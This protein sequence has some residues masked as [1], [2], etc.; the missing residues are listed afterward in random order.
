M[1][2]YIIITIIQIIGLIAIN[3]TSWGNEHIGIFI[4]IAFILNMVTYK[5]YCP[6]SHSKRPKNNSVQNPT[7]QIYDTPIFP[8][9]TIEMKEKS[10][11]YSENMTTAKFGN[12]KVYCISP[13]NNFHIGNYR[14][15]GDH[16]YVGANDDRE[17]GRVTLDNGKPTLIFL[18]N[19]GWYKHIGL[20]YSDKKPLSLLAAEI[21]YNPDQFDVQII[22]DNQTNEVIALYKGDP[23]GAAAAF[24]CMQYECSR[25]GRYHEFY[26]SN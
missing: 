18:S 22:I 8:E 7:N 14:I 25:Y 19:V 13:N 17:I 2:D 3:N 21:F 11:F 26:H 5:S 6:N 23:I 15:E 16:V 1:V 10:L 9:N 20:R 12:G 4:I 24:V